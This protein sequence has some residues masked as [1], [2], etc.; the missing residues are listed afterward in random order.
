MYSHGQCSERPYKWVYEID[1]I[2]KDRDPT[3][4]TISC[5]EQEVKIYMCRLIIEYMRK[6][7]DA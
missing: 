6:Q 1:M 3:L 7:N 2:F 5:S 4:H